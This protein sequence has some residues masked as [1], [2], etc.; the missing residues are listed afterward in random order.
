M[1]KRHE[2]VRGCATHSAVETLKVVAARFPSALNQPRP[3]KYYKGNTALNVLY[4]VPVPPREDQW[5]TTWLQKKGILA[6]GFIAVGGKV[7]S[8]SEDLDDD[9]P[10][11]RRTD[12]TREPVFFHSV[13]PYLWEELLHDFDIGAVIDLTAGDGAAALAAI[14]SGCPYA[15]VTI[16]DAH[17]TELRQHLYEAAFQAATT[18]GDS[19]YDADL[20]LALRGKTRK[21]LT[22]AEALAQTAA[23][24]GRN[25]KRKGT[26]GETENGN[27]GETEKTAKKA[28]GKAKG[29]A[30]SKAKAKAKASAKPAG[31]KDPFKDE[32]P[33]KGKAKV[34][35]AEAEE[36]QE[37]DWGEGEEDE[38]NQQ[39]G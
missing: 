14:R 19:L 28:K 17:A 27:A 38:E 30:K 25:P 22:L 6:S 7:N 36:D 39:E 33:A 9:E 34:E 35:G 12:S 29:K 8:N 13:T 1:L 16:T 15:G 23:S 10:P 5:Q 21:R 11:A 2:R 37:E 18:E 3:R 32:K 20:V 31:E 24:K 4:D 26:D